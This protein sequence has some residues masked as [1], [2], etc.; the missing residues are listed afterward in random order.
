M[1]RLSQSENQ[2]CPWCH[3]EIVWDPE[4]GPE[5]ECPH[6]FNELSDYRSINLKV[7]SSDSG[8]Q[9]DDEEELDDDLELSDEELQLADDYGEGV[10]Q[11]LDS[12]EEAPECSSC[13]S[14]MLLAGTESVSEAFVPFVHPALGKPLLQ[15]SFSVQVYLCPSCFRVER[16]LA[17]TDRLALVEQLREHGAKK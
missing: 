11:L 9:Y 13:H 2:V 15:A 5:E 16:Q 8:I 7:E 14:F 17:E 4:I 1:T 12:Q 10:Q 6:C 3:T